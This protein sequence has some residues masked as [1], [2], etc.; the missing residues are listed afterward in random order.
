[1]PVP[2]SWREG[3]AYLED[4]LGLTLK[5]IIPLIQDRIMSRTTYFGIKTLKNPADFWVY[6]EIL[7]E[8]RPD[9]VIEIGNY[10][11]GST[12]GLAHV[13]D[14][15]GHGKVIGIDVSHSTVDPRVR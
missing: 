4:S 3:M 11:G 10:C 7:Y 2:P 1:M 6:Q 13:C 5:E 9:A 12:L 15:L 8:V 14:C